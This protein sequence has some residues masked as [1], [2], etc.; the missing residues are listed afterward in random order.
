LLCDELL[1]EESPQGK[2]FMT[3]VCR[4]WEESSQPGEAAGIPYI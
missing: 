3:G 2:D 1:D 4:V